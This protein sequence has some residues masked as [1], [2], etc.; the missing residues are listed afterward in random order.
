MAKIRLD[1]TQFKSSGVYTVELDQTETIVLNTQTTRLVVGFS[2][3]GPINAPVFCQDIKTAK[4]IFG[5]IDTSLEARGSFFHRS[6]FTCLE[7]GPCFAL[8]LM[9][10]ND[11]ETS[12][13][14]D[15]ALFKSFSLSTSE[16]N[17]VT[18]SKLYS[19]YFNK[20]R[21]WFPDTAYLMANVANSANAG[22]VLSFVNLGQTPFSFIIKKLEN[23]TGFNVTARD[24]FG[25]GEVPDYIK[26]FDYISEYFVRIDIV[27]GDWTNYSQLSID[28][29]FSA[30]F[31]STGI[32][33][34]KVTS[35]LNSPDVKVIGSFEGS[36]IPDLIDGNGVNYSIDT[37]V[38]NALAST[39]LFV[40]LN[41]TALSQYDA[42][43][44]TS[45]GRIDTIGH[46][47][48]S[49]T[50]TT[51][52]NFLSYNFAAKEYF[53]YPT[54][55]TNTFDLY[56]FGTGA[57]TN[58][59]EGLGSTG[60]SYS[61]SA[62]GFSRNDP[63]KAMYFESFY[64]SGNEGKFNNILVIRKEALSADQITSL[65]Q[66]VP[67]SS[68]LLDAV[69]G[70]MN[71]LITSYTE[72]VEGD[73]TKIKLGLAHP[74]KSTEGTSS[75]KN[76][77]VA[78]ASTASGYIV[79]SGTGASANINPGDW[80]LAQNSG[81]RYYFRTT[82]VAATGSNTQLT[83]DTT[84]F[85]GATNLENITTFYTV[86]WES[87]L[88]TKGSILDVVN[89]YDSAKKARLS[90][91]YEPDKFVYNTGGTGLQNFYTSYEFND[92]YQA[93]E[94]GVLTTGDKTYVAGPVTLYL[95]LT[96]TR[97]S[98]NVK[99]L[100]IKLYFDATLTTGYTGS[101]TFASI[102]DSAGATLT[103][104]ALRVYS[105]VGDY[106]VTVGATGFDSNR[107]KT[108]IAAADEAKIQVGQYLVADPLQTGDSADFILTR[109]I[110][111]KKMTSGT[112]NTYYEISVNQPLPSSG[113]YASNI[114]R[115]KSI[116][117]A[118]PGYQF[119]YLPGFK[120]GTYHLPGT[121]AQL[122]KILGMLD[123]ANS[124]LYDTLS[125]RHI[126]SYRYIVDTFNGGLNT[127]S[128][129][130]NYITK[131]AKNR[132]KCLAIMNT[133]SIQEF[134]DST[135]PRFTELPTASNPKPILST[136]Y[137]SEGG[138]LSL[139]PSYT[140]SL[141]DEENGAKYAG[142][143]APW[144]VIRDQNKNITIPPAADVSNNFVR[145]FIA[146]TPYAITAGPRRGVLSNPRLVA[147]EYDFTDRDRDYLEPF[148]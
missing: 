106:Q 56:D 88:N 68:L 53:D 16:A 46:S 144:L 30:Y 67:G 7:T 117:S 123:S 54:T 31:D 146:G 78:S 124:N 119:T 92:V 132:Q 19:S 58:L 2:K 90:F 11:D 9:P 69:G 96:F 28:P 142:F 83:I 72:V 128:Y 133:P 64:G 140:Y 60:A 22:K 3:K 10:L 114:V 36:L 21:F 29:V 71:A 12:D 81:V 77:P 103:S 62:N 61:V 127:Q 105:L 120:V 20:E 107:V 112:Y 143:F 99:S 65:E 17:G 47:L 148:G 84:N 147:L 32:L 48:I 108:Y 139:G 93:F 37:I 41:R 134:I 35:F 70:T 109:V 18:A 82:A 136:R 138:N 6:L 57:T 111:K 34:D 95:E 113:T 27:Q 8:N 42:T 66:I 51:A 5:E 115:Y 116:D 39:G 50:G 59:P 86:Y 94:D 76:A 75:G 63:A 101:W 33:K 24:W 13:N 129:P 130:K 89:S 91:S 43:D 45:A 122:A 135:D 100:V 15:Y 125:E 98:D 118:A 4:R 104:P 1:L 49:A 40:A 126:I 26:E 25:S 102:T 121:Q 38:N 80:I 137:I 52:I 23:V 14:P 74:L 73:Y 141:P 110:S 145:K 87:V 79:V 85:N 97:D 131:L 44:T 55:A